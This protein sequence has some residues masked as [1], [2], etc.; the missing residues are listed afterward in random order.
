MHANGGEILQAHL[1]TVLQVVHLVQLVQI[2]DSYTLGQFPSCA[3]FKPSRFGRLCYIEA[4]YRR[5]S[6]EFRVR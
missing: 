6:L 1:P 3:A 5:R 2:R 4:S